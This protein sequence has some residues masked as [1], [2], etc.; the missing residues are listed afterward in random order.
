ME[1]QETSL[2]MSSVSSVPPEEL[3]MRG[4]APVVEIGDALAV[5]AINRVM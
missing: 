2:P 5:R 4:V 1:S 3:E